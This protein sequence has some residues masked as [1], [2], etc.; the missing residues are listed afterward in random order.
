MNSD[1][2][3]LAKVKVA[4]ESSGGVSAGCIASVKGDAARR[5]ARRNRWLRWRKGAGLLA[6]SLALVVAW[7]FHLGK[8]TP[9][10]GDLVSAIELL[11]VVDGRQIE[12]DGAAEMLLAW[13]DAPYAALCGSASV[14][15]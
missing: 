4:L 6:A 11:S 5:A 9:S 2:E 14:V 12:G 3:L 10:E 13:Q 8:E 15:Q 1:E 7:Q